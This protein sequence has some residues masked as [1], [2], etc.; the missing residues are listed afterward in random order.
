[1]TDRT[2]EAGKH[3]HISFAD[4]AVLACPFPAYKRLREEAPIYLDP[5]TGMYVV[6]R[7]EH[8]RAIAADPQTFANNTGQMSGRRSAAT[9]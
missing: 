4:P 3:P 9:E 5:S 7:Y 6:T 2:G 8:L 1:M